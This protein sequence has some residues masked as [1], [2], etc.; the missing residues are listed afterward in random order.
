MN[1]AEAKHDRLRRLDNL[2]RLLLRF[3]R[4]PLSKENYHWTRHAA[5][6][7]R[8]WTRMFLV[9]WELPLNVQAEL[10]SVLTQRTL[11]VFEQRHPTLTSMRNFLN[12][13]WIR[14]RIGS[15]GASG[16][17]RW[18]QLGYELNALRQALDEQSPMGGDALLYSAAC[19]LWDAFEPD[20][21]P[22][23]ITSAC[24]YSAECA[25]RAE[26][27]EAWELLDSEAASYAREIDAR[28]KREGSV[29]MTERWTQYRDPE[30]D[31][32]AQARW[33]AGW[34]AATSWLRSAHLED[35]DEVKN[36]SALA[37]AVHRS[38]TGK[39]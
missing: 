15:S 36:R 4:Q 17:A 31:P 11:P 16:K 27:D 20:A 13:D 6:V 24:I 32:A 7:R 14:E 1:A 33:F 37:D 8:I 9:L 22:A 21:A 28:L 23:T 26:R 12:P 19:G 18:E 34:E 29:V 2:E 30:S 3:A 5:R 10:C 39:K 25:V 38:R 35:Y